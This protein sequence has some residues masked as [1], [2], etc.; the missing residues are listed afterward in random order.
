MTNAAIHE[1]AVILP[2][3][4][5]GNFCVVAA[6]VTLSAGVILEDFAM[7][8]EGSVIGEGTKIGT[9]C[10]VGKGVVIGKHCSFT[11]YCEIRDGCVLGDNV[12][13]G[14]RGT[15]SAGTIVEDHV[16]MKYSFVVTDTPDLTRNNEKIVGR[17]GKGAR[18]GACVA[19]MPGVSI[20]ENAEIGAFSLVR[21]HI[22]ANE[23]WYG[24]PAKF[25]RAVGL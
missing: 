15:L 7:V 3:V 12:L 20:G 1:T 21:T 16:I 13:M 22:P 25:Y 2:G 6:N 14:S 18:F 23:I 5:I 24:I 17:I 10:K 4:K 11:S 8:Q 9:Y 19:L